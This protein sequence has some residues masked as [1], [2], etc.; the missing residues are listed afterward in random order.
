M[1]K[2][3]WQKPKLIVLLKENLEELVLSACKTGSAGSGPQGGWGGSCYKKLGIECMG[4]C[5]NWGS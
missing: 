1:P 4:G 2:K 3:K 5:S